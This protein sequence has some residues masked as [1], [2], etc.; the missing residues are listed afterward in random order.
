M[1]HEI[2]FID[3]FHL[4]TYI[5]T[6]QDN[7]PHPHP[8]SPLLILTPTPPLPSPQPHHLHLHHHIESVYQTPTSKNN[9]SNNPDQNVAE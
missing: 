5:S 1:R 6:Y 8:P 3:V 7:I 4:L 2:G 9:Q